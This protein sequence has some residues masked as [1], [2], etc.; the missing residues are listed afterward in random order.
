MDRR[1]FVA[2]MAAAAGTATGTPQSEQPSPRSVA[3]SGPMNEVRLMT[4]DP[5]HF[6]A[7][8]VQ[9]EMVAGVSPEVAV[10]APLGFD[11][12]EHLVR[13]ARFNHRPVDPTSWR[14]QIYAGPDFL[15]RMLKERPG[16]VVV[17]SGRNRAKMDRIHR[18]IESGLHV[19][20]DKP[21]VL[22]SGDVAIISQALDLAESKGLVAYDIMT[23][24]FEVTS[25]LQ[26]ELVSTPD[27]FGA[28]LAGDRGD[29]SVLMES[30]H[31]LM[32][33]VAGVP[34]LRPSWFFDTNEQGE[35]LSDVG[36]HLIDLAQWSVFPGQAI[37]YRKE[38]EVLDARHW[39]T[40]LTSEQWQ[41]VTGSA[42]IPPALS[43]YVKNGNLNYFCNNFVAYSLRGV[44]IQMNVLWDFEG[45]PPADS[46]SAKFRGTKSRV[47][48]RQGP[49]E[50][51]RP[52]V[53]VVPNSGVRKSELLGALRKKIGSLQSGLEGLGVEER[54]DEF[55]LTIPDIHRVGHEAHF[56][57]VTR[58]FFE[59]LKNPKSLPAWEKPNMLA[60][61]YV[62]TT[63]VELARARDA[64]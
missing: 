44:H 29:P 26:R 43:R 27:V 6:H 17:L 3:Q 31:R 20:A 48:V 59:F 23:E 12:T 63:G 13:V 58:R 64:R 16:N 55:R 1:E 25:I 5:A 50:N 61:Y 42:E 36:T 28:I 33:S 51:F 7:A 19:L 54:G 41:R 47:E 10:Y 46:Y 37:D 62:S 39:P 35:A 4:L 9:K 38:I 15:E 34:S 52:E 30:V 14:L 11:L 18:S 57:Q 56:A 53:Y 60:K 32:K 45:P 22:K 24:R 40:T 2:S 49:A 21:W 8:L